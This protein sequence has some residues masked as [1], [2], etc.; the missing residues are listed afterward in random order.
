MHL[1]EYSV[2]ELAGNGIEN[3]LE[4]HGAMVQEKENLQAQTEKESLTLYSPQGFLAFRFTPPFWFGITCMHLG[5]L[6]FFSISATFT[7]ITPSISCAYA[8]V[9]KWVPK[10]RIPEP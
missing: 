10:L 8:F 4:V 7:F 9:L 3:H 1:C 6:I 5:F 2:A